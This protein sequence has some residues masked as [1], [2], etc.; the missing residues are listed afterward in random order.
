MPNAY[1]PDDGI[2]ASIR[3]GLRIVTISD[4]V[5]DLS[6]G[7]QVCIFLEDFRADAHRGPN[8]VTDETLKEAVLGAQTFNISIDTLVDH[9]IR[10]VLLH[11]LE[12]PSR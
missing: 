8:V 11:N 5:W 1:S 3:A 7:C 12:I 9:Y 4:D 2:E 10:T 6:D